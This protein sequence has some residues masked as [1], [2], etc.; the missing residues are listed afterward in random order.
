MTSLG[1]AVLLIAVSG[2]FAGLIRGQAAAAA[3]SL[4]TLFWLM[5]EWVW[6]QWRLRFQI[7]RLTFQRVVNDREDSEGTLQAGR[8]L[9]AQVVI[10]TGGTWCH[11]PFHIEDVLPE[12]VDVEQ[13]EHQTCCGTGFRTAVFFWTGRVRGAGQLRL[14]GFRIVVQ[15]RHG[16]FRSESFVECRQIFRVLPGWLEAGEHRPVI[17]RINAIPRHGIHRLQRAGMGSELL[18]LRDYVSGDPPKSIAWKVSARRDRLMT[19]QYESEVPIRVQLFLDGGI[20]MRVGGFGSRLLDQVC[21][22]A[23]SVAR[24]AISAGDSAGLVCFDEQG[25]RVLGQQTGDR[26]FQQLLQA[27]ADFAVNPRPQTARLTP[28]LE[29]AALAVMGQQFPHLLNPRIN[30]LPWSLFPVL[31]WRRRRQRQRGQLSSALAQHYGMTAERQMQLLLDDGLLATYSQRFL[32]Q[33]GMAWLAP[34]VAV[35]GRGFHDGVARM[36]ALSQAVLTAVSRAKDN[37]VLVILADLLESSHGIAHLIPALRLARARHH[38]VV[39][40]C[41]TPTFR[42]PVGNTL[43]LTG[44][45]AEDLLMAAEQTRTRGLASGL[46]RELRRLGVA[47]AFAGESSAIHTVLSEMDLARSGRAGAGVS[48]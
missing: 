32:N 44:T 42:R 39:C 45:S 40:V 7:P 15:D 22:V 26:G 18:E 11:G 23:A 35:R 17:K 48:R 33:C 8:L 25:L 31:P 36:E 27:M 16:F 20:S 47:T 14:P 46:H 19:R 12:N 3:L 29:Q 9:R 41:P 5:L 21:F 24:N 38:R 10:G 13:S 30:Y 4:A 2:L 1:R 28:Q 34:V 43:E 6:F 37:E